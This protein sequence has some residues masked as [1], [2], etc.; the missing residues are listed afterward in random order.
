MTLDLTSIE[1][2]LEERWQ[3]QGHDP[4]YYEVSESQTTFRCRRCDRMATFQ[5]SPAT[6]AWWLDNRNLDR[7]CTG[8]TDE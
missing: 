2:A 5:S 7:L 4:V 3:Q 8:G 1:Q 6:N